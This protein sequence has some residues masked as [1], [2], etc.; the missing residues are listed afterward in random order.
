MTKVK[1]RSTVHPEVR[2]MYPQKTP[3]MTD[4]IRF[5]ENGGRIFEDHYNKVV[6]YKNYFSKN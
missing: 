2:C 5:W 3:T 6:R 1:I 4:V